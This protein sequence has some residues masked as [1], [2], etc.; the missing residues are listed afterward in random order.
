MMPRRN[1]DDLEDNPMS[2][3]MVVTETNV[4]SE[5]STGTTAPT[6][7]ERGEKKQQLPQQLLMDETQSWSVAHSANA[8][9]VIAKDKP[10]G[11]KEDPLQTT[12]SAL[13]AATATTTN[14]TP[15]PKDDTARDVMSNNQKLPF[16]W[17]LHTL[18]DNAEQEGNQD[19]V[20][21]E[22]N[23]TSFRVH[24]PFEFC[25][26]I[27]GRYFRQSKYESFTR[28]CECLGKL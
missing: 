13:F 22:A 28:Q 8:T 3:W 26:S 21:W 18:L 27:L 5:S 6:Q 4:P 19:I 2:N 12:A 15:I 20:S 25:E 7:I 10:L 23:G 24:K 16:P 9:V 11:A 1:E 14:S 17:K